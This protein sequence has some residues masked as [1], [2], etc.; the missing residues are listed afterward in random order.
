MTMRDN[1]KGECDRCGGDIGNGGVDLAIV[2]GDLDPANPGLV[3][4]LHFCRKAGCD[5]KVL[6]AR[7]MQHHAAKREKKGGK[8]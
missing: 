7:N 4:N 5:K 1:G 2:V 6:S 3:R 8:S